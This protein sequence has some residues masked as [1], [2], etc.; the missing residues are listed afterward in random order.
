MKTFLRKRDRPVNAILSGGVR[1]A[2]DDCRE[3]VGTR[4]TEIKS[5]LTAFLEHTMSTHHGELPIVRAGIAV[6]EASRG[7][8]LTIIECGN[9]P[10]IEAIRLFEKTLRARAQ[11]IFTVEP[12]G[13]SER[14]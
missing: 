5:Q 10:L 2:E 12:V 8:R 4:I 6:T 3:R 11:S 1:V 7:D 14:E 13:V 9:L